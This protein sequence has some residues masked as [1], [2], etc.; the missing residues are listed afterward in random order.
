MK[1]TLKDEFPSII[2]VAYSEYKKYKHISE[3]MSTD[4]KYI[5]QE[6]TMLEA[7]KSMGEH[8]IGSLLVKGQDRP[9]GIVTERDLLT[10]VIA[11]DKKP[12]EVRVFDVYSP[13]L[14]TIRPQ[15]TIR[16]GARMMIKQ[17]GKLVVT[18]ERRVVGIVTASD[19][20]KSLP[21]AP[22]TS[23]LVKNFMTKKVRAVDSEEKIID[24]AKLMGKE[25]I[26]SVIVVKNGKPW[27][28]FTERDLLSKV[29]FKDGSLEERVEKFSSSPL[30]TIEPD[31]S[32]HRAAKL[33]VSRHVRRLP[34]LEDGEMSGIITAR[35]LVEAYSV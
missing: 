17:K 12:S 25:R 33:M 19:L 5:E 26:G 27:G 22:E 23:V 11:A 14:V 29:I 2:D 6:R 8:H 31:W 1:I 35:D 34:I 15:A 3:I 28:I 18:E 7:A 24:V 32:I 16:E 9:L 30:I 10:R 20:I 21:E 4:L 13:R